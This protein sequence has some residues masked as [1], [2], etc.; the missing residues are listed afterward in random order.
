[1]MYWIFL[2]TQVWA[3]GGEHADAHAIP[4]HSIGVQALN[5]GFLLALLVFLLRKSVTAHFTH[6]ATE[7]NQ[8]VQKAEAAKAEAEKNR[9]TIQ[10][11]LNRLEKDGENTA[12]QAHTEAQALSA[13]LQSEAKALGA[14][15][16]Q[17]ALRTAS[18]EK[19]KAKAEL[20]TSLLEK[21]LA[22]AREKMQKNLGSS[23][24]KK[25]QNE[26]VEKIQVVGG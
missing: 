9:R 23:D 2:A 4:W 15:I 20:R 13:R 7:Y 3:A 8:L 17:E 14:K 19:E 5:F 6:R 25:L 12:S 22:A 16:E 21:S 11:R 18:A 10:D 1:M 24:Q 26:F